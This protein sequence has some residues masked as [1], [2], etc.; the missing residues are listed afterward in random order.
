MQTSICLKWVGC[1]ALFALST[2]AACVQ[3]EQN[4]SEA[5]SAPDAGSSGIP[6]LTR[7]WSVQITTSRV[8]DPAEACWRS[9][10]VHS[11]GQVSLT[12]AA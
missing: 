8:C 11:D 2:A 10:Y 6:D 1:L 3:P 9:V 7:E 4:G 12:D 5:E